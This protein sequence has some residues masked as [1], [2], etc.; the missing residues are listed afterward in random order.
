MFKI[1]DLVVLCL[2]NIW[3]F[4]YF[5]YNI[6]LG[7][8]LFWQDHSILVAILSFTISLPP[9]DSKKLIG[10]LV[11]ILCFTILLTPFDLMQDLDPDNLCFR[12]KAFARCFYS[13]YMGN[14]NK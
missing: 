14:A 7:L 3:N 5:T 9:F 8:F 11:A 12:L 6:Y 13:I 1:W 10:I 2:F 4:E